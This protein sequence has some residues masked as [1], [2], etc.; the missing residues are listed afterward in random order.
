[1]ILYVM[2]LIWPK[3]GA[4]HVFK[5]FDNRV[6]DGT[7]T[8]YSWIFGL[9]LSTIFFLLFCLLHIGFII[10]VGAPV[11]V[12]L[13][14]GY[15]FYNSYLAIFLY[16]GDKGFFETIVEIDTYIHEH[17]S[18]GLF[19]ACYPPTMW[20]KFMNF[21]NYVFNKLFRG[22]MPMV[23]LFYFVYC[24]LM[25]ANHINSGMINAGVAMGLAGICGGFS[26]VLLL[27]VW[28]KCDFLTSIINY[29]LNRDLFSSVIPKPLDV[30]I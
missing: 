3:P 28:N 22:G 18:D 21:S 27:S 19:T 29:Y 30:C 17:S 25:Y 20:N 7:F 16:K 24:T 10:Y 9:I 5:E 4:L 11:G 15:L 13:I 14:L 1:M 2:D 23:F 26:L 12:L 6:K 8:K